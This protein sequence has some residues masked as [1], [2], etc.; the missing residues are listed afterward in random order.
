MSY[1]N[2]HPT[3]MAIDTDP[4]SVPVASAPPQDPT[5]PF[6]DMTNSNPPPPSTPTR[7]NDETIGQR[8]RYEQITATPTTPASM[9]TIDE[10]APHPSPH[11]W[12]EDEE[13]STTARNLSFDDPNAQLQGPFLGYQD[14]DTPIP[15]N[16][17][18]HP[19]PALENH[20]ATDPALVVDPV[21]DDPVLDDPVLPEP[22]PPIDPTTPEETPLADNDGMDTPMTDADA[23]PTDSS[24]VSP[25][26]AAPSTQQ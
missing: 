24:P 2:L 9:G 19:N 12:D 20:V 26:P 14:D 23:S 15:T 7:P 8:R 17:P 22:D 16:A 21:L 3:P 13:F 11:D 25:S 10:M 18:A 5:A 6:G 1:P 4:A